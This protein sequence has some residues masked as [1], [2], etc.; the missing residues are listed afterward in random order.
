MQRV[1]PP[2]LLFLLCSF[3]P[4]LFPLVTVAQIGGAP[5]TRDPFAR[6]QLVHN[7]PDAGLI[8]VYLDDALWLDDVDFRTATPFLPVSNGAHTLAITLGTDSTD[9]QPLWAGPLVVSNENRYFLLAQGMRASPRLSVRD[10]VRPTSLSGEPEFFVVHGSPETGPLDIRLRDPNRHNDLI[11]LI[12]N[13]ITFGEASVY[14][15]LPPAEYNFEVTTADNTQVLDV[16]H[17]NLKSYT[18]RTFAFVSSDL[19]TSARQGFALLAYDDA[20]RTIL[21]SISTA[22]HSEGTEAPGAYTLT[23]N[24][25]NPFNPTTQIGYTTPGPTQVRLV[26]YDVLGR[27]V[28]TLVD[29]HQPSGS[30]T[31]SW[32]GRNDAGDAVATGLYVYRMETGSLVTSRTMLL[33]K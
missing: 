16:F 3:Y 24:Y 26:V 5:A 15:H 30:Y 27:P 17:F 21:P 1:P 8:D 4:L 12:I 33:M 28:R 25:P 13:N 31:V 20:G 10:K 29:A 22:A 6:V 14:F 7:I 2:C 18:G 9:T 23:Q 19:G 32:D 11:S